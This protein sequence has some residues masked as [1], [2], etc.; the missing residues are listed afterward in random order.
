MLI[1]VICFNQGS[2]HIGL[3]RGNMG[4]GWGGGGGFTALATP[5]L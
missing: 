1:M 5:A 3:K 2:V 4:G